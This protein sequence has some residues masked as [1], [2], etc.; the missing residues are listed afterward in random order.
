[1]KYGG[2]KME[3]TVIVQKS[4]LYEDV[5][6]DVIVTLAELAQKE[7]IPAWGSYDTEKIGRSYPVADYYISLH[8]GPTEA[9]GPVVATAYIH[10]VPNEGTAKVTVIW[11]D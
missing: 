10:I 8:A 9:P 7:E 5:F 6:D 1:M 3:K 2:V 4:A 11:D